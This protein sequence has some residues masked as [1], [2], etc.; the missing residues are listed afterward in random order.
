M[1][2]W[3]VYRSSARWSMRA[4][5]RRQAPHRAVAGVSGIGNHRSDSCSGLIATARPGVRWGE[6]GVDQRLGD[7]SGS[8]QVA[9]CTRKAGML[10]GTGPPLP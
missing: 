7:G 3:S 8:G 6:P 4:L 10:H 9:C 1:G 2:I 5:L